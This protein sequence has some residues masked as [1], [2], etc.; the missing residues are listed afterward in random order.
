LIDLGNPLTDP[1]T[2][3]AGRRAGL[4][5]ASLAVRVDVLLDEPGGEVAAEVEGARLALVEGHQVGLVVGVEHQVEG[6]RGVA[7]PAAAEFFAWLGRSGLLRV[8]GGAS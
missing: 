1:A 3:G 5:G 4:G 2:S 6:G 7:E 8:H